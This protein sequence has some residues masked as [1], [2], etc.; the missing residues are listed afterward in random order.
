MLG[1]GRTGLV[2]YH[3]SL[4]GPSPHS[5]SHSPD[6][7]VPSR[8]VSRLS[9]NLK[10]TIRGYGSKGCY[11]RCGRYQGYNL[12]SYCIQHYMGGM[13][14]S[15]LESPAAMASSASLLEFLLTLA[16]LTSRM[17][18]PSLS[19]GL[20]S[21]LTLTHPSLTVLW[22]P[23]LPLNNDP[24]N[25][26]RVL[27]GGEQG[28]VSSEGRLFFSSS[29]ELALDIHNDVEGVWSP[30]TPAAWM[31]CLSCSLTLLDDIWSNNLRL[32]FPV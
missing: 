3:S 29:P 12:S 7:A 32:N 6:S 2:V 28:G 26:R 22:R 8:A 17:L 19:Q 15:A 5:G 11:V 1:C 25:P 30:Q 10:T 21:T 9:Q 18:S 20:R 31:F 14:M 24:G 16:T 27:E 4:P 23:K 13:C